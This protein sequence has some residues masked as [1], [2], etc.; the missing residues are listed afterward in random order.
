MRLRHLALLLFA[1]CAGEGAK[2]A[3]AESEV[4][5]GDSGGDDSAGGGDSSGGDTSG[6]DT[7]GDDTSGDTVILP[8]GE[9]RV[10]YAGGDGHERFYSAVALSDGTVLLAG[11]ADDLDW[12]PAGV[13][14]VT[15]SAEGISGQ[16]GGDDVAFLLQVS[17]DL[18]EPLRAWALPPG[19]ASH[20][21]H[22][23]VSNLPGERTAAV[24]VS[25]ETT[26]SRGD[27]TGLFIARLDGDVLSGEVS[28]FLWVKNLYATG[29]HQTEQPWD[30]DHQG[31]VYTIRGEPYDYNWAAVY[32]LS[33]MTGEP[34]L[35]EGWRY[36]WGTRD[37]DG[38]S[39]E[40]AGTPASSLTDYS[41]THSA[42]L[43]KHTN[44]CDLRSWA[45]AEYLQ[46]ADDGNGGERQGAWP[47]DYFY[48]GPCDPSAASSTQSGPGYTG[49][50]LGG[51]S[52]M[53]VGAIAVDRRTDRV[54]IGFSIQSK[55]PDGNPDFEPAVL[56]MDAEG[57]LLWWSR[58]YE[59][60]TANS[61]PDQYVD[62][63]AIDAATG[64]LVV[65]ARSH[66]NNVVNLWE[67]DTVAANPSARGFHSRFTGTEGNIHLSWIGKL[68]LEDGRLES[69]TY[70]GEYVDSMQGVGAAYA[71]P[72]LD[73]WP[74]HDAGWP[75]LN[76]TRGRALTVDDAGRVFVIAAGRRTITTAGAFQRMVK[77]EE[78]SSCWNEFVRVY[79][80][81]LS[82]VVY[83]SLLVGQWDTATQ[84]GGDNV[85]LRGLVPT[86]SGVLVV[87]WSTAEEDGVASGAVMPTTS[88]PSWG[89]TSPVGEAL[90][91][92]HLRLD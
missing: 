74:D 5:G 65:L 22:V 37:T 59:E 50:K 76:T 21:R 3:P 46:I 54:Y 64:A 72:N 92:G 7:S 70:L 75:D 56:A 52:T 29:D 68:R 71:D 43:F 51:A 31:R 66:G 62:Q 8:D 12:L 10:F 69:A 33:A 58:L 89:A 81:D 77:A 42:L 18:A 67:G 85:R 55:L 20:L 2:D 26:A 28:G 73:G 44:R 53:R 14:V 47:L 79:T 86:A 1:A 41:L 23:K 90:V 80:P 30:V 61:S 32:R 84:A 40:V 39:V 87:G 91:V 88:A 48:S 49:Y 11:G 13:P 15:L 57:G 24:Y 36:H 83:S 34:E 25:G 38:A 45:E 35:V 9:E 60:T 19:A 78:G 16:P 63:F 27:D 4:L 6:G 82:N 17:G